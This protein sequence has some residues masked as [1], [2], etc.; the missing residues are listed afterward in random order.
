[1]KLAADDMHNSTWA[2]DAK[3]RTDLSGGAKLRRINQSHERRGN[4]RLPPGRDNSLGV[5][6]GTWLKEAQTTNVP[7]ERRFQRNNVA[8]RKREA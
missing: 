2:Q 1:M 4:E 6:S 8:D 5:G 3:T 7:T